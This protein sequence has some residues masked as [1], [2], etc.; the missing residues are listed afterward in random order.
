[1]D[2]SPAVLRNKG[3]PV[4]VQRVEQDADGRWVP[5]LD[6]DGAAVTDTRYVRFDFNAIADIE[7]EWGG[8]ANWEASLNPEDGKASSS[9]LRTVRKTLAIC[10]GE[11][12]RHVGAQLIPDQ[13]LPYTLAMGVAWAL[14]NGV[15]PT[16]AAERLRQ[17]QETVAAAR[18]AMNEAAGE[19]TPDGS[20][21]ST[22]EN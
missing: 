13:F 9:V 19:V 12:V 21:A 7:E 2:F 11:D 10:W 5:V 3:V 16:V 17:G 22:G 4:V 18:A 20:E 15:D 8:T 1:M 6:A 14:A